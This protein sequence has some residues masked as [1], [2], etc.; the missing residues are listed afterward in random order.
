MGNI[1]PKRLRWLYLAISVFL[2]LFLGLIYAWSVFRVP[3]AREFGWAGSELS[4]TFS[5]SM[6]MFCLGGLVSGIITAR[7]GV[8]FTLM[9]SAVFLAAGFSLGSYIE[10]LIGLYLTY[11][12]LAGFGSGL[13]Y[14]SS[15]STMVRWFPDKQGLVSGIALM[16]FGFGA[17]VLG[18]LG[19]S[20]IE[21]IGWRSTFLGFGIAFAIIVPSA[22]I[23]IRPASTE[24]LNT[25]SGMAKGEAAFIENIGWQQMLRRRNFWLYF[26]WAIVLSAAGLAVIN[27]SAPYASGFLGGDLTKAAAI[28]GSLSIANG[29]GRVLFGRL[30]D[31]AGYKKTMLMV[32]LC[33]LLSSGSLLMAEMLQ[34]LTFL[35]IG[36][37]LIGLSY[38]GVTPTNS[39]Y[40]AYFFGPKQYGLNFS[41]TNLNLIIASYLGPICAGGSPT[42][43]FIIIAVLAAVGAF[44]AFNIYPRYISADSDISIS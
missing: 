5:V 13:G 16:G 9:L 36:F 10:S 33:F 6:M 44:I 31:K 32:C 3:L 23:I 37:M 11:G 28:A 21:A 39:A 24:F 30:F 2:L 25:L 17:M 1:S 12:V 38:G 40:T 42:T 29:V 41:I 8:R 22:A 15:I 35:V 4:L 26:V 43:S 7:R 20:L 34:S 14:N 27:I 18:T 19:A